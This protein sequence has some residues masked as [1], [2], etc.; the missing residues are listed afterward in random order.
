MTSHSQPPPIDLLIHG[1][2]P[3]GER[4][5]KDYLSIHPDTSICLLTAGPITAPLPALPEVPN[6]VHHT[7]ALTQGAALNTLAIGAPQS[8]ILLGDHTHS[9]DPSALD[10]RTMLA[11]MVLE[12]RHPGCYVV[13]ELQDEANLPLA[14]DVGI[15]HC[16]LPDHF[17]GAMLAQVTRHRGLS[18]FFDDLFEPGTGVQFQTRPAAELTDSPDLF[19]IDCSQLVAHIMAHHTLAL[20]GLKS[21]G[22]WLIPPP[23]GQD[24]RGRDVLLLITPQ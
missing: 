20:V 9:G 13:A 24:V 6:L 16:V 22:S 2:N 15:N 12:S 14:S 17:T 11:A 21:D 7:L 23:P 19:P 4:F 5:L 10:A 1:W 8:A 18:Y 3:S